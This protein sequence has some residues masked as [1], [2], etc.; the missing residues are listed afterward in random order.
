MAISRK[1]EEKKRRRAKR[2][3]TKRVSAKKRKRKMNRKEG[4]GVSKNVAMVPR[5]TGGLWTFP[6]GRVINSLNVKVYFNEKVLV[7][8]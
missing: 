6:T 1:D 2:R 8:V 4:Q 5:L 7:L 3:R